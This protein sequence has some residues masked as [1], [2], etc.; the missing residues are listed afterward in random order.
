[1]EKANMPH[2]DEYIKKTWYLNTMEFYSAKMKNDILSFVGKWMEVENITLSEAS[3]V[4][5][6]ESHMFSLMCGI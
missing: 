6:T 2:S 4:Q 3:Q 5:K 1:M